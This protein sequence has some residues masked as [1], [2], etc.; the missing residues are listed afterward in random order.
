MSIAYAWAFLL[1]CGVH[2]VT[3]VTALRLPL[4]RDDVAVRE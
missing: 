3:S 2:A 4:Q 1:L